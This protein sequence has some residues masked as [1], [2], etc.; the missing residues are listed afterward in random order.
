VVA[1][2]HRFGEVAVEHES[3]PPG[4]PEQFDLA[5]DPGSQRLVMDLFDRLVEDA[6]LVAHVAPVRVA[7]TDPSILA[8]GR[9]RIRK[10]AAVGRENVA[11]EPAPQPSGAV[12]AYSK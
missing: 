3:E 11:P 9:R 6:A 2:P 10:G 4:T 1:K 7:N 12:V 5:G 8:H